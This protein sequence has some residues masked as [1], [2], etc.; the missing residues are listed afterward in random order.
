MYERWMQEG[1]IFATDYPEDWERYTFVETVYHPAK[2]SARKLDEA[3][4]ELRHAAANTAWVWRRTLR[5]LWMTRSI[6]SALFIHGMN[7][8]WKRMAIMQ[9]SKDEERFGF[10]PRLNARTLKLRDA[11]TL[12]LSKYKFANVPESP[13]TTPVA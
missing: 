4:Y 13:E 7:K 6:T 1:K 2:I 10:T 5:T 9:L 3:I 12:S 11:F 8:G